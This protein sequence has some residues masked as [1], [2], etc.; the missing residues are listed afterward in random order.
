MRISM[1]LQL[2]S[3]VSVTKGRQ[4]LDIVIEYAE[5]FRIKVS[6]FG[7]ISNAIKV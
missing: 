7:S 6:F 4:H 3:Y 1:S 5:V 2:R